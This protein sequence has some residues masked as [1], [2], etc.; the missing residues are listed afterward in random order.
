MANDKLSRGGNAVLYSVLTVGILVLVNVI[1][2]RTFGR[3]DLTQERI[4]TISE[5]SKKLV[6]GLPDRLTIKAFISADL[7]PQVRSLARYV[8]DMLDEYATYSKGKVSWEALDPTSDEKVKDEARRLKV[9]PAQLSVYEKTKASVSQSYLGVAFQYGGKVESLPFVSRMDDLEYEI[10]SAIRRL[11]TKKRKIGFTSGHG[12]AS[13]QQGLQAAKEA[14][15]DHEVTAVD[16]TEGKTPIPSDVDALVVVGPTQPFAERAKYEL[17]QFLMKGKPVAFF[18]DG[19]VLETPR[20]SFGGQAPPRIARGN[21]VGLG[22]QLEHYGVKMREDLIFDRQNARVVLPAAGGQRV[23]T[24]YPG[25]PVVTTLSRESPI[26]RDLKAFIPIFPSSLELV[27]PAKSGAVKSIV[28]AS[29]TQ[30]SWRHTGFFL[31]DPLR[32]PEP[33]KELGPFH[34]AVYLQGSFGSYFAGKA[35][36]TVGPAGK[37]AEKE[38]KPAAQGPKSAPSARLVVVSDAD[39]VKDQFLGVFPDNLMLLHNVVDYLAQDESLIAI[40]AK[41]QT[42]RPLENVEDSTVTLIRVGNIVGVPLA[43][44]LVGLLRWRLRR[45]ARQ[46]RAEAL[47]K[48]DL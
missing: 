6:A 13:F 20:G 18:L 11:S 33:S 45:A 27:G 42:R 43:L 39:L 35:V 10:S 4:Y 19:M 36:P 8:R 47:V 26:S 46:R 34:F 16:L 29:S 31:F 41:T 5:A 1:A 14:L 17:D 7:P 30:A 28:L 25:F 37:L 38:Q 2:S 32:Q 24:N 9:Q 21:S 44:I 22:E 15:K 12:E 3:L 40:R 48:G 23:I